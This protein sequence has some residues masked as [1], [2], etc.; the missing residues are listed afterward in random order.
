MF[1]L[2]FNKSKLNQQQLLDIEKKFHQNLALDMSLKSNV[3]SLNRTDLYA[4]A[5]SLFVRS[6]VHKVLDLSVS[7]L[8]DFLIDVADKYTEAPY[9]TFYHAVDI[10]TILY[11]LCH[12]LNADMYLTDLDKSILMVAALCHDIGHPGFTNCF[13]INTKTELA[14]KYGGKSTLETYSVYLT[15]EL[16]NKH[17]TAN[18]HVVRDTIKDLILSTDMAYHSE[19]VKQADQLSHFIEQSKKSSSN[20]RK[21]STSTALMPPP[22]NLDPKSRTSLCRILLHAA[23]ISN[24]ARPWVISKQWSDLIVQEFF[25]QGDEERKRK[26]TISPGMDREVC[27]QS[28]ISLKFGQ[29][30]LPYFESLV[31]LLPKS[32]VFVDFLLAN[33]TQWER[34]DQHKQPPVSTIRRVSSDIRATSTTVTT[35]TT[36]APTIATAATAIK[37]K[38]IR[39]GFRSKSFPTVLY[40]HHQHHHYQSNVIIEKNNLLPLVHFKSSLLYDT[41]K[42]NIE[43]IVLY[44]PYDQ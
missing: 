25:S 29:L 23:D 42:T 33:R 19:L 3:L 9:H 4:H 14:E 41:V 8:L 26:M 18:S 7:Q 1:D 24:M 37:Y 17:N 16:L 2:E 40:H 28:S 32:H 5:L 38:R 6:N 15:M 22:T 39:L 30:I 44:H 31:S 11:Y 12:D 43:S 35:T 20:K 36:P 34:L 27:S 13:Q 21:H 10:V